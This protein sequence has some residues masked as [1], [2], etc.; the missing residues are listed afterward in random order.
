M[1]SAW[2]IVKQKH[3]AK[4]FDGEG[5]RLFGGRWNSV[6]VPMVYLATSRALALLEILVHLG[7]EDCLQSRYVMIRVDYADE[8]VREFPTKKL[9][10]GWNAPVSGRASRAIGDAFC[11]KGESLLLSVPSVIVPEERILLLNPRHADVTRLAIGKP[12][13]LDIDLR[14]VKRSEVRSRRKI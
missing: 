12:V 1:K 7:D 10:P 4:A 3:A 14:L 8:A 2:R 5:A 6:G 11:K 9:A 13:A